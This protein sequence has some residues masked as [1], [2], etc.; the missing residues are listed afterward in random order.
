MVAAAVGTV[1]SA[2]VVAEDWSRTTSVA[3][4]AAVAVTS[5]AVTAK[6][7][8]AAA[9]SHRAGGARGPAS[10]QAPA[11]PP[12]VTDGRTSAAHPLQ[13]TAPAAEQADTEEHA[14]G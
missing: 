12:A 14:A 4:V 10:A 3:V 6:A 7:G 11:A 5:G 9:R 1:T 2:V 13:F 8:P